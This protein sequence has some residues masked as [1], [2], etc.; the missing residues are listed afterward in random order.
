[1]I[2]LLDN[3]V[4][5]KFTNGFVWALNIQGEVYQWKLN[6]GEGDVYLGELKHIKPLKN[7]SQIAAGGKI[8]IIQ[9]ITLLLLIEMGRFLRWDKTH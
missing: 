2:K 3:V 6:K 4:Q 1:M 9:R 5:V 7:I 8:I